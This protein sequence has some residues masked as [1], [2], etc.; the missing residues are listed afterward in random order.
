MK[1]EYEEEKEE[2]WRVIK[3]A[4][5]RREQEIS[6]IPKPLRQ[7]EKEPRA[8]EKR[9]T[10]SSIQVSKTNVGVRDLNII[11]F[12]SEELIILY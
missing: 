4:P 10:N 11:V 12:W 9:N 8:K 7:K 3:K 6:S 2:G 1:V 5:Q